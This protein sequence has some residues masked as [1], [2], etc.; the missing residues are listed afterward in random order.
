MVADFTRTEA[1][2]LNCQYIY[3]EGGGL[4]C[5]KSLNHLRRYLISPS[6]DGKQEGTIVQQVM[7]L[8]SF[9][10]G[11]VVVIT[12]GWD[13]SF[14]YLLCQVFS[15]WECTKEVKVLFS[16]IIFHLN[17]IYTRCKHFQAKIKWLEQDEEG[18]M[19]WARETISWYVVGIYNRYSTIRLQNKQ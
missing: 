14:D 4:W 16:P 11:A 17:L 2:L 10:L 13:N 15:C 12:F 6:A 7:R 9:G 19:Y 8:H 5:K 18:I 3:L 1:K